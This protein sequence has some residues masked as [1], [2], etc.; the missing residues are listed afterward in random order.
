MPWSALLI[1]VCFLLY[2]DEYLWLEKIHKEIFILIPEI[3]LSIVLKHIVVLSVQEISDIMQ[4]P[5]S[6][7]NTDIN[8]SN[9]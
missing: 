8:N 4:I 2:G 3:R 6:G 7:M 9:C 5:I 1:L